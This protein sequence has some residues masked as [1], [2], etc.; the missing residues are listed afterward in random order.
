MPT[1]SAY[2]ASIAQRIRE[3][4]LD[5]GLSQAAVAKHCGISRASVSQW[6]RGGPDG[7]APTMENLIK[8]ADLTK[9][10]LGWFLIQDATEAMRAATNAVP[11]DLLNRVL[12]MPDPLR[13]IVERHVERVA[14]YGRSLPSWMMAMKPPEDAEERRRWLELIERDFESRT[15]RPAKDA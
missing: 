15:Q 2:N 14:E 6:E 13:A 8:L 9:R 5:A 3:A 7:S 11:D 1:P 12:A 4:R 10:P